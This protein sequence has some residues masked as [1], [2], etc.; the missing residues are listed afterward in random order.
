[1]HAPPLVRLGRKRLGLSQLRLRVAG[2]EGDGGALFA[3]LDSLDTGSPKGGLVVFLGGG[4][5]EQGRPQGV[6]S[7]IRRSGRQPHGFWTLPLAPS[8]GAVRPGGRW[9]DFAAGLAG[10]P[11]PPAVGPA[12]LLSGHPLSRCVLARRELQ[13]RRHLLLWQQSACGALLPARG[14]Q[15]PEHPPARCPTD[16]EAVVLEL[17]VVARLTGQRRRLRRRRRRDAGL[18][19]VRRPAV[20]DHDAVRAGSGVARVRSGAARWQAASVEDEVP[21]RKHNHQKTVQR[22]A[23][24]EEAREPD[25]NRAR[26]DGVCPLLRAGPGATGP[27]AAAFRPPWTK[28]LEGHIRDGRRLG[29]LRAPL[30][31]LH[32]RPLLTQ[33]LQHQHQDGTQPRGHGLDV[34]LQGSLSVLH[35]AQ[36]VVD[37][38][39]SWHG[40]A[41]LGGAC[42]MGS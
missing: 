42:G 22:D 24:A 4:G 11:G 15:L 7:C 40:R 41:L 14:L 36:I 32:P 31:G 26:N 9:R 34:V 30:D 8:A 25:T 6:R 10:L 29:C 27:H 12:L 38:H 33:G 20:Q 18:G 37:A 23:A 28:P 1:M 39:K 19:L 2:G 21:H 5:G 16:R 35:M 17:L 13:R 3:D